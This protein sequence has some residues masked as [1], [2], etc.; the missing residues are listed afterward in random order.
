MIGTIGR[1][2]DDEIRSI[3]ECIELLEELGD[4]F[5]FIGIDIRCASR[6]E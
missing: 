5:C 2:D 4:F 6:D 1:G 3:F